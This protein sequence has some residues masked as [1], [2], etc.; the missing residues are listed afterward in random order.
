MPHF[1]VESCRYL[2]LD[3][4]IL[5]RSMLKVVEG[6]YD[7]LG[8]NLV[9]SFKMTISSLSSFGVQVEM[10]RRK[11]VGFFF[12]NNAKIYSVSAVSLPR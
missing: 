1:R 4:L 12:C 2:R 5:Q 11:R 10:F 6:Y 9:E 8:V 7:L 3:C